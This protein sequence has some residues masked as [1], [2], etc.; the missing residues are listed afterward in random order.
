[1]AHSAQKNVTV[2]LECK[3]FNKPLGAIKREL[4]KLEHIKNSSDL[5]VHKQMYKVVAKEYRKARTKRKIEYFN[6]LII[7]SSDNQGSVF[8]IANLLHKSSE[9]TLPTHDYPVTLA[10]DF[11]SFFDEKVAKIKSSLPV[12]NPSTNS[13]PEP[14]ASTTFSSFKLLSEA[15]VLELIKGSPIKACPLDPVP[16]SLF[17]SC[18]PALLLAP[19]SIVN[20]SLQTSIVPSSLKAAQLSPIIKKANLDPESLSNYRPISNLNYVSKLVERTC[21]STKYLPFKQ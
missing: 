3:W 2:R 18:L 6:T 12:P 19:T 10:Q 17:K 14:S 8:K 4:R 9:P 13:F 21:L 5:T 15:D 1:M 7:E 16:A 20:L 11:L